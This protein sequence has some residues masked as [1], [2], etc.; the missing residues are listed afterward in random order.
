VSST[1]HVSPDVIVVVVV[2]VVV[3]AVVDVVVVVEL[4]VDVVVVVDGVGGVEGDGDGA[5]PA[6]DPAGAAGG[7]TGPSTRP[8]T[9]P[10]CPR[11][12]RYRSR[13]MTACHA[14]V[15]LFAS[16]STSSD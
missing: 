6:P 4:E 5:S 15:A 8:A 12:P 9:I 7:F 10:F 11:L 16:A 3:V 2:V 14:D 13:S 1:N